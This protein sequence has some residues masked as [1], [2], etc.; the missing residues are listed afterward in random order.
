MGQACVKDVTLSILT[1]AGKPFTLSTPATTTIAEIKIQ[2][3]DSQG[4]PLREQKHLYWA[5]EGSSFDTSLAG[6]G[7]TVI[8]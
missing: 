5:G 6:R 8:R 7:G 2:I 3:Q 1:W 4:I